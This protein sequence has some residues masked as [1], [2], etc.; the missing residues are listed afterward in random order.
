MK[1]CRWL[2]PGPLPI[3][4]VFCPNRKAWDR[5]I[6]KRFG[7]RH[8]Y[9]G[10]DGRC[11]IYTRGTQVACVVTINAKR[12]NTENCEVIALLAHEA[13]HVYQEIRKSMGEEQPSCEFE[14]YTMQWLLGSLIDAFSR[15]RWKLT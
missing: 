15:T 6:A 12:K 7:D 3:E 13:M 11:T 4:V 1:G 5:Q 2:Q 10:S 9:P 14:A 8:G